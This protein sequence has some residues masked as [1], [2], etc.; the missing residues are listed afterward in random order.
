MSHEYFAASYKDKCK[1]ECYNKRE[2]EDFA[3]H[4]WLHLRQFSSSILVE[5]TQLQWEYEDRAHFFL[6]WM[7]FIFI[8][9]LICTWENCNALLLL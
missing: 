6:S 7:M 2:M 5:P 3:F 9:Q 8:D 4:H 1:Q